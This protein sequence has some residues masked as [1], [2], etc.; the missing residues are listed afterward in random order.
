MILI[1]PISTWH[2]CVF[3][4]SDS[5]VRRIHRSPLDSP[6]KGQHCRA[7]MFSL[8][9][10]WTRCWKNSRVGSGIWDAM[11][12][13]WRNS[14]A[15]FTF[16]YRNS[17]K[18]RK[19]SYLPHQ[20]CFDKCVYLHQ[21]MKFNI[22]SGNGLSPVR[23]QA[24]TWTNADQMKLEFYTV[25]PWCHNPQLHHHIYININ[26]HMN[27]KFQSNKQYFSNE[28]FQYIWKTNTTPSCQAK[29]K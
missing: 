2:K 14:N 15:L 19:I 3:R 16:W 21:Q 17:E 11:T 22:G 28:L 12:L 23:R 27:T 9:L 5:F 1:E 6:H 4:V 13:M 26:K 29:W 8:I 10:A 25:T 20:V 7:L 24:I 18:A